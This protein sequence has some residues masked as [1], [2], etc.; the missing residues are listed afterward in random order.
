[1]EIERDNEVRGECG[2]ETVCMEVYL[3][4]FLI[5]LLNVRASVYHHKIRENIL[6]SF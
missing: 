5:C 4:L 2:Q 1:M 6:G 3:N